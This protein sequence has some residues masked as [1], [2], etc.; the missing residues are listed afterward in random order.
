MHVTW[1]Y[2]D[3]SLIIRLLLS[4]YTNYFQYELLK[5]VAH[6]RISAKKILR[7]GTITTNLEVGFMER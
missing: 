2:S 7:K 4:Y 6:L 5:S 3:V 1:S